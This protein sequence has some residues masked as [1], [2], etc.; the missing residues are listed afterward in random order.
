[1]EETC[2]EEDAL[3]EPLFLPNDQITASGYQQGYEPWQG[4]LK[5]PTGWIA[6]E[7]YTVG[8]Y[9]QVRFNRYIYVLVFKIKCM[10]ENVQSLYVLF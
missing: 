7:P 10:H 8:A 4:R 6:D 2:P 1:M 5:G 3:R 9:F